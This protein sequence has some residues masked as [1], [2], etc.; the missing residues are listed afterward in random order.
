MLGYE[1]CR[2]P[3]ET[4]RKD[5]R[6]SATAVTTRRSLQAQ[7]RKKFNDWIVGE[8]QARIVRVVERMKRREGMELAERVRV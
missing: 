4:M 8:K 5:E 3:D 6:E 7:Y 1:E 2:L